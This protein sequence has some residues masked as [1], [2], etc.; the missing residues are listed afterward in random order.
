MKGQGMKTMR[1][2][3]PA[4]LGRRM[5]ATVAA[6]LVPATALAWGGWAVQGAAGTGARPATVQAAN[7]GAANSNGVQVGY[8]SQDALTA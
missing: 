3:T 1:E 6:G 5:L 8:G 4:R 2:V 7:S